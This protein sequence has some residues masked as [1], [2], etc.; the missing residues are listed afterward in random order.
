MIRGRWR[1]GGR[2]RLVRRG[3]EVKAG[4]VEGSMAEVES[5]QQKKTVRIMADQRILFQATQR[6]QTGGTKTETEKDLQKI[7]TPGKQVSMI[8]SAEHLLNHSRGRAA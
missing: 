6:D 2:G 8:Y 4:G 3:E 5:E 1:D 7:S